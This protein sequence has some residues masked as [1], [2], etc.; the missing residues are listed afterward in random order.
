MGHPSRSMKDSA[1]S[2]MDY[3]GSAQKVSKEIILMIFWQRLWLI[4]PLS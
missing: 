4:F 3:A 2:N 1:K